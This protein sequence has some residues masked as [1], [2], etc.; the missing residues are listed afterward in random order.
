MELNMKLTTTLLV[1]LLAIS[2]PTFATASSCDSFTPFGKPAVS[3]IEKV[4]YLCRQMYV[5]EHSPTR[6]TPYWSAEHLI[7]SQQSIEEPRINAFK[8]DPDLPANESAKPSDYARSGYDKGHMSPVGDM[9]QN[10]SAMLE[11]FYMSN[12]V[13]Q[14]PG[15]NRDGWRAIEIYAREMSQA[16][17]DI[18]V[19]T[20]PVYLPTDD[21]VIGSTH[22]RV[23]GYLYKIMYDPHSNAILSFMVPNIPFTQ[24]DIPKYISR[25]QIIENATGINFFPNLT[26]PLNES[27]HLWTS[28]TN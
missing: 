9:H 12:M 6:H 8:A 3:T 18:Y 1:C 7:G 22:V 4:T 11:S 16:R 17:G 10:T 20:G 25:I 24:Q 28:K 2:I 27:I 19:I 15:N 14:V 5:V 23:P 13:P 21:K 26:H